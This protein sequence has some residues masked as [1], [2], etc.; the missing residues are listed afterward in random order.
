MGILKE[1]SNNKAGKDA[2]RGGGQGGDQEEGVK[3]SKGQ[4]VVEACYMHG[5]DYHKGTY[6]F[7]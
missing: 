6:R 3:D 1:I 4:N 7:I 5:W 2:K